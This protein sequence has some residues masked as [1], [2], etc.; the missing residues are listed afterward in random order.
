M[1]AIQELEPSSC[2]GFHNVGEA[3]WWGLLGKHYA[4]LDAVCKSGD[5]KSTKRFN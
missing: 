4:D 2:F 1:G 5:A 3:E